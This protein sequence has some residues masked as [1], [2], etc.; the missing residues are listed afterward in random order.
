MGDIVYFELPADDPARAKKFYK[1]LFGWEFEK[2]P[3]GDYWMITTGGEDA[4]Y[5][6]LMKREK[7]NQSVVN[8]VDV[9]SVEKCRADI[10]KAGGKILVPKT[11]I[12]GWGYF[13]VF[14]DTE[15]NVL[16]IWEDDESAM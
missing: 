7:P 16:G 10:E 1:K 6:G 8:Y 12:K 3:K 5:G 4:L 9:E 13:A 11:P 15:N 14:Q 2:I